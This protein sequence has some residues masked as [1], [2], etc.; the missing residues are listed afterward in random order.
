MSAAG[1]RLI[2]AAL[3]AAATYPRLVTSQKPKFEKL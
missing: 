2:K 3:Q 1:K